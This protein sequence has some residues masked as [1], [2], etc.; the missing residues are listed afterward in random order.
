MQDHSHKLLFLGLTGLMAAA[1]V[2][3]S[4]AGPTLLAGTDM[5]PSSVSADVPPGSTKT[6]AAAKLAA[7]RNC[8]ERAR[9]LSPLCRAASN[10]VLSSP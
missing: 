8:S 5:A 10:V 6:P 3:G 7:D 1:C 4:E 2:Y 9:E